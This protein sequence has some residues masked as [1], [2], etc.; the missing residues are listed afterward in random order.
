MV[1]FQMTALALTL[2][3][4]AGCQSTQTA[5]QSQTRWAGT[6]KDTRVANH[7]GELQCSAQKTGDNQWAA[8][9][10]GNCGREYSYEVPMAGTSDGKRV[11]FEGTVDLGE[12]DGGVYT[13]NGHM[14]GDKFVGEY[15]TARGKAGVFEMTRQ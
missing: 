15:S 2:V 13:W 14:E 3:L 9:F 4:A 8:R 6:W 11:A 7:G 5:A 12:K 1:R 10:Y